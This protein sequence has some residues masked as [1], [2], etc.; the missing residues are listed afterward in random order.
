MLHPGR[1]GRIDHRIPNGQKCL[2]P[3]VR[4]DLRRRPDFH[5]NFSKRHHRHHNKTLAGTKR[6]TVQFHNSHAISC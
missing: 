4:S 6:K 2:G 3:L 1:S 5:N